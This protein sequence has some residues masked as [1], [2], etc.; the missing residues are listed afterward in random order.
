VREAVL[1]PLGRDAGERLHVGPWQLTIKA[2]AATTRGAYCMA[3]TVVAPR[4]LSPPHEHAAED[5]LVYVLEGT[6]GFRTGDEELVAGPGASVFRP[7]RVAHALWNPTDAP[8]RILEISSPATIEAYF[9]RADALTRAGEADAEALRRL[10]Q[11]HGM[12]PV[13]AWVD[14]LAAKHAVSLAGGPVQRT[15]EETR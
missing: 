4:L 3:E 15:S 8:A 12:T 6:I 2:S 9:R 1:E 7:R 11:E 13:V 14:E 5:Q 10:G